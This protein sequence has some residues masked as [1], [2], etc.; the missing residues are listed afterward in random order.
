MTARNKSRRSR[1]L[2]ESDDDV[3]ADD[4]PV[5]DTPTIQSHDSDSDSDEV[6]IIAEIAGNAVHRVDVGLPS[7]FSTA[8]PTANQ[9]AALIN[10]GATTDEISACTTFEDIDA[11]FSKYKD[12]PTKKQLDALAKRGIT[13]FRKIKKRETCSKIIARIKADAPATPLQVKYIQKLYKDHGITRKVPVDLSEATAGTLI[14]ELKRTRETTAPQR[15]LLLSLHV[16]ACD[17]PKFF[18]DA[19][20]LIRRL[21]TK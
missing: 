11:L 21:N 13:D 5:K 8:T 2:P 14:D 1:H 15:G 18:T 9:I 10:M 20:E 3:V 17:I 12:M 7:R 6:Q 16:K 19:D 4:A